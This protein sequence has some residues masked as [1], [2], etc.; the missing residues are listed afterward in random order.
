MQEVSDAN[1]IEINADMFI[2]KPLSTL[3]R[4][5]KP[6]IKLAYGEGERA[7]GAPS[8][9]IFNFV[10][11]SQ[12]AQIEKSKIS[13]SAKIIVYVKERFVWNRT[14]QPSGKKENWT[15]ADF[16]KFKNLTVISV[17]VLE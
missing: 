8:Y 16:Q 14:N 6:E 3:L 5:I 2:N 4:E 9:L 13:A 10:D 15:M 12:K 17:R 11:R 1:K 7:D